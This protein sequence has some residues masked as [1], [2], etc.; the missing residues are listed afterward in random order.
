MLSLSRRTTG[1]PSLLSTLDRVLVG[2]FLTRGH[3][4]RPQ[5]WPAPL[6]WSSEPF[7]VNTQQTALL[8]PTGTRAGSQCVAQQAG[9]TQALAIKHTYSK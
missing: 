1:N 2:P 3:P 7:P 9:E 4:Q 6:S 5:W 8:R